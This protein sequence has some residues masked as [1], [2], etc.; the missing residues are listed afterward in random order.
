[1]LIPYEALDVVMQA[2][3]DAK[4]MTDHDVSWEEFLRKE[5][6]LITNIIIDIFVNELDDDE[7]DITDP[8][9]KLQMRK[10]LQKPQKAL[11]GKSPM[12]A[13]LIPKLQRKLDKLL[14]DIEDEEYDD[15]YLD[16]YPSMHMDLII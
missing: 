11:G 10:F 8:Y 16:L 5:S 6:L 9:E 12:E 4:N 3:E 1:M 7:M 13:S 15:T 14:V 2:I